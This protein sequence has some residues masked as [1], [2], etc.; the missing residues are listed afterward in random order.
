MMLSDALM[1]RTADLSIGAARSRGL[2]SRRHMSQS[3]G[4]RDRVRLNGI[5]KG[6][7]S[8]LLSQ[9]HDIVFERS[10]SGLINQM[11]MSILA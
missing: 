1:R 10:H 3:T 6:Y 9:R 7:C 5:R 11:R 8:F 2:V 4:V